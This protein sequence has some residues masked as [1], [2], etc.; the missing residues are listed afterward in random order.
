MKNL[1]FDIDKAI[2]G[3]VREAD[4]EGSYIGETYS[5]SGLGSRNS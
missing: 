4:N 2:E 5:S 3:N 1:G